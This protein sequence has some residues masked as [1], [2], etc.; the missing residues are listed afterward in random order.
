M[1]A[2][3]PAEQA[4]VRAGILRGLLRRGILGVRRLILDN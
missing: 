3:Q 4:M 1:M 2:V